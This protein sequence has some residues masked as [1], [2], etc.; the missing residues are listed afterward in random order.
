ML[1]QKSHCRHRRNH[2]EL[3]G[4]TIQPQ[5]QKKKLTSKGVKTSSGSQPLS[6]SKKTLNSHLVNS[7][8]AKSIRKVHK[9][10]VIIEDI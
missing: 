6:T 4:P 2:S 8:I 1:K 7:L 10:Q 5:K 3:H 9:K